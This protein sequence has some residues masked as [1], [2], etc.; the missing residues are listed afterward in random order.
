MPLILI[1]RISNL[2]VACV[3]M[4]EYENGNL[5][6]SIIKKLC[7]YNFGDICF[8]D[9]N[10]NLVIEPDESKKVIETLD[11]FGDCEYNCFLFL[12]LHFL[13]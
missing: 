13:E 12:S 11:N 10:F 6:S 3:L 9:L 2:D 1:F 7:S 4:K 5:K 8:Q